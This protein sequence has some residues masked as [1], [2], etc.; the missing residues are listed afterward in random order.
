MHYEPHWIEL[1]KRERLFK[2]LFFLYLPVLG[3]VMFVMFI[4]VKLMTDYFFFSCAIIWIAGIVAA[5]LRCLAWKC[6]RCAHP[7]FRLL[8]PFAKRCSTCGLWKWSLKADVGKYA[9]LKR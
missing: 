8:R 4:F 1:K 5:G 6:P 2:W 9:P 3:G 7:F